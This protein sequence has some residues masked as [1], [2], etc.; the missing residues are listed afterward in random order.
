[1]TNSKSCHDCDEILNFSVEETINQLERMFLKDSS[2]H[3]NVENYPHT[4]NL[5][6]ISL[7]DMEVAQYYFM[8]LK[9]YFH[10]SN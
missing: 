10:C 3:S 4:L 1:M 7:W 8:P 6:E 9:F 2:S 5:I